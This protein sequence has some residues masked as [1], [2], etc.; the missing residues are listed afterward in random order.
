MHRKL[1]LLLGIVV[2][3]SALALACS[4]SDDDDDDAGHATTDHVGVLAALATLADADLHHVETSLI[5]DEPEIDPTWIAP[6]LNARTA[7]ALIA[8]PDELHTASENFLADSMPLLMALQED[9]LDAAIEVAPTAHASWHL[10]RDPGYAYLAEAAGTGSM[11]DDGHAHED[12]GD[13]HEDG[14][15]DME[16][17][18]DE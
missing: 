8:W 1:V 15:D 2:A 6:I 3:A 14:D 9:D 11:G 12:D 4:D 5:G 10:L 7:V 13:D 16:M 18:D 17:D